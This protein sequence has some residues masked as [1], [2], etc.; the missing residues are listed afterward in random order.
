L[1]SESLLWRSL[2]IE[3]TGNRATEDTN[4]RVMNIRWWMWQYWAFIANIT[5]LIKI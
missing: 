3:D 4:E 1:F 5:S 2:N